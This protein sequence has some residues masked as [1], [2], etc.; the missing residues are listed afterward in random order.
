MIYA[1]DFQELID[2][3]GSIELNATHA[4]QCV[5]RRSDGV[6]YF[7]DGFMHYIEPTLTL[8]KVIPGDLH[9]ILHATRRVPPVPFPTPTMLVTIEFTVPANVRLA[10]FGGPLNGEVILT[11]RVTN[12]TEAG[13][14]TDHN[15]IINPGSADQYHMELYPWTV[16]TV[17]KKRNP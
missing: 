4:I 5:C 6:G 15:F 3:L 12:W 10:F 1:K 16:S 14:P 2:W 17:P 11:D 13:T 9:G 8:R 7:Y